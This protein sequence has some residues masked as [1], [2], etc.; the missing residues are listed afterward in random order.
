LRGDQRLEKILPLSQ[1]KSNF[2]ANR[3]E[4]WL[5]FAFASDERTKKA[6]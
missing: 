6:Q 2:E 1:E 4:E 3:L 5:D